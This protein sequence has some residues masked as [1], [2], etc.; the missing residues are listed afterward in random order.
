MLVDWP[1]TLVVVSHDRY[2]WN[3]SP[4]ASWHC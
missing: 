1:G 2:C 3:A 4:T